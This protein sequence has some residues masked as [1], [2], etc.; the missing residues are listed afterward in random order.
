MN[1]HAIRSPRAIR[2]F[3]QSSSTRAKANLDRGRARGEIHLWQLRAISKQ[4]AK[5]EIILLFILGVLGL[6]ATG[7]GIEGLASFVKDNATA[8]AVT[9]LL[10]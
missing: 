9:A 7:Y 1:I 6:A 2:P 8:H 10:R 4:S 5:I 3:P